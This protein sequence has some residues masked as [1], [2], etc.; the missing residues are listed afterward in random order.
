MTKESADNLVQECWRVGVISTHLGRAWTQ[1]G[2][3]QKAQVCPQMENQ[4]LS[5]NHL[6]SRVNE[7]Q[8]YYSHRL[9]YMQTN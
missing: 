8:I 6:A 1:P 7:Y 5:K 9:N 4:T 3:S 2:G